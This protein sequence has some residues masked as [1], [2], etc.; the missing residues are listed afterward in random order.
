MLPPGS[1]VTA[2]YALRNIIF[3]LIDY[4][5][6]LAQRGDLMDAFLTSNHE[7]TNNRFQCSLYLIN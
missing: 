4:F 1:K 5:Q 6:T 3:E 2:V 7:L